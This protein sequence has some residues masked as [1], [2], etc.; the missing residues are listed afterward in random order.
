MRVVGSGYAAAVPTQRHHHSWHGDGMRAGYAT[1]RPAPA[2]PTLRYGRGGG[3][4]AATPASLPARGTGAAAA[5]GHAA[6]LAHYSHITRYGGGCGMSGARE[7][8]VAG[9]PLAATSAQPHS[10]PHAHP[11][12]LP[13]P[14]LPDTSERGMPRP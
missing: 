6:S 10:L 5:T 3:A 11:S 1:L 4:R 13:P 2:L 14:S 8:S 7:R 9:R 12:P